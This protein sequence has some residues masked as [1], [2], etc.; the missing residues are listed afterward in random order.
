MS[1]YCTSKFL[2]DIS[3]MGA[4]HEDVRITGSGSF[5]YKEKIWFNYILEDQIETSKTAYVRSRQ[6][7]SILTDYSFVAVDNSIANSFTLI[8][9]NYGKSV[10]D[11]ISLTNAL[12]LMEGNHWDDKCWDMDTRSGQ[13]GEYHL[14]KILMKIREKLNL[15]CGEG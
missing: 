12:I 1:D 10:K 2:S 14:G 6:I 8:T 5:A 15:S 3:R 4:E 9:V 11:Y 7:Q 13:G